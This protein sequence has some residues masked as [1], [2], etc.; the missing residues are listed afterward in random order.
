[1]ERDDHTEN[2]QLQN[3][4]VPSV[5]DNGLPF[6]CLFV[7]PWAKSE[8]LEAIKMELSQWHPPSEAGWAL[9]ICWISRFYPLK[10]WAQISR[11]A[12]NQCYIPSTYVCTARVI[13][14]TALLSSIIQ[15]G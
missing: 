12:L 3:A 7:F 2:Y 9:Q 1:M 5:A 8:R 6:I 11:I 4:R 13:V 14:F 10:K 15:E